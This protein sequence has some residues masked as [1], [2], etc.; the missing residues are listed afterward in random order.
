MVAILKMSIGEKRELLRECRCW[1]GEGGV[2]GRMVKAG[3]G[4]RDQRTLPLGGEKLK[5]R[6]AGQE[7]RLLRASQ[8][9]RPDSGGECLRRGGAAGNDQQVQHTRTLDDQES[10]TK[11]TGPAE[12]P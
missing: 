11:G 8:D 4:L 3:A 1:M 7:D 10:M 5:N 6:V 9:V 12:G 2:E